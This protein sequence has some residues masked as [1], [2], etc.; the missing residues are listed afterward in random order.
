MLCKPHTG[1]DDNRILRDRE[2]GPLGR[3]VHGHAIF[4]RVDPVVDDLNLARRNVLI[5]NQ[6]GFDAF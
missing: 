5:A 6:I 4:V 3:L 2:F 1:A